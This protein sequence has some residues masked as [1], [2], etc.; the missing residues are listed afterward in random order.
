MTAQPV[1]FAPQPPTPAAVGAGQPMI[2]NY[3]FQRPCS[4]PT[5]QTA[6]PGVNRN[7]RNFPVVGA[8]ARRGVRPPRPIR[9]APS[10]SAALSDPVAP[11]DRWILPPETQPLASVTSRSRN[12]ATTVGRPY[13]RPSAR[14]TANAVDPSRR[15]GYAERTVYARKVNQERLRDAE[16][17]GE[18]KGEVTL[19]SSHRA[20]I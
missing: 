17:R 8:P 10:D 18:R 11:L 15:F 4:V 7:P 19:S 6:V 13:E 20:T 9:I 12:R 2:T 16:S 3:R 5:I 14:T 1:E